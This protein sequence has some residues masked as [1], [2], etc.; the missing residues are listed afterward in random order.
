MNEAYTREE[1]YLS[2][3]AGGNVPDLTP[4][5]RK[6]MFLAAAAGQN[7]TP[8][9]PITRE[10]MFLSKIQGGGGGTTYPNAEGVNF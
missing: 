7:V 6:E 9:E 2:A 8:P 3:I 5:T 4:I 1:Q 10:E